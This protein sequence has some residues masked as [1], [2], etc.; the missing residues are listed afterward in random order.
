MTNEK[1]PKK[2]GQIKNTWKKR[3]TNF[4]GK[5]LKKDAMLVPG[6]KKVSSEKSSDGQLK[7]QLSKNRTCKHPGCM[8]YGN[9]K[10][11]YCKDHQ[12]DY[13]NIDS[14]LDKCGI[15]NHG[16]I[17]Y[18]IAFLQCWFN[19]AKLRSVLMNISWDTFGTEEQKRSKKHTMGN[20]ITEVMKA[21]HRH[22]SR[23]T[24]NKQSLSAETFLS[25]VVEYHSAFHE[26]EQEDVT[27]LFSV[28]INLF[29]DY[30]KEDQQFHDCICV[31]Y[32]PAMFQ[33][34]T[35]TTVHLPEKS[36]K[37]TRKEVH[38]N[39]SVSVL[40]CKSVSDM[41]KAYFAA[42]TVSIENPENKL[43]SVPATKTTVLNSCPEI[44]ALHFNI[45]DASKDPLNPSV[46]S[47]PDDFNFDLELDLSP[48]FPEK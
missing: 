15:Q 48:F 42:E 13:Q 34:E 24:C 7:A 5:G 25:G 27:E 43:E 6:K 44:L 35:V 8:K 47:L 3:K 37:N 17:C 21:M 11:R 14:K 31:K 36:Y 46:I 9:Q 38:N 1:T 16:N 29:D 23:R 2:T 40:D 41:F 12:G 39:L 4:D 20:K 18:I 28:M 19:I 30:G 10:G 22:V 32:V 26:G 33:F 45:W